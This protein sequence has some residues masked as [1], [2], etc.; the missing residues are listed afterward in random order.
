MIPIMLT[1]TVDWEATIRVWHP[2]SHML[3]GFTS[4]KSS[5][6]CT[7]LIKAVHHWMPVVVRKWL[8]DKY[9]PGVLCLLCREVELS[10]HVFTCSHNAEIRREIL[11]AASTDWVSFAGSCSL[12]SSAVL[13][14]LDQYFLDVGLYSAL[15]KRFVLRNWCVEAIEV[16]KSKKEAVSIV[17]GFVGHFVELHCSKT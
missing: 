13:Q 7:Y 17:V 12:L 10:D 14:S 6:L 4:R 8:Y 16:L 9:Y 2:N 11:A 1:E 15:C 5:C 3:A